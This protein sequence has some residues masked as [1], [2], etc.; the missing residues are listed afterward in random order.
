[1]IYTGGRTG[2]KIKQA[3]CPV[4]SLLAGVWPGCTCACGILV[5]W[6]IDQMAAYRYIIGFIF[7]SL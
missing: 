5:G 1:M 4:V 6:D 3:D 7:C 2:P